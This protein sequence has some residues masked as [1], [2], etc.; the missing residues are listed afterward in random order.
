MFISRRKLLLTA[1]HACLYCTHSASGTPFLFRNTPLLLSLCLLSRSLWSPLWKLQWAS[2][3]WRR[4]KIQPL[5]CNLEKIKWIVEKTQSPVGFVSLLIT[6]TNM[7]ETKQLYAR[8]AFNWNRPCW[9]EISAVSCR[10][11]VSYESVSAVS[12]AVGWWNLD[13]SLLLLY[14]CSSTLFS[15]SCQLCAASSV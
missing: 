11:D 3:L 8:L 15:P 4:K 1:F 2:W 5:S 9:V 7:K 12:A 14:L 6:K 10:R 13:S